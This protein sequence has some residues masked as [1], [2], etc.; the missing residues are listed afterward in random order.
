MPCLNIQDSLFG[1]RIL[2]LVYT[3]V[4]RLN[5][6][7]EVQRAPVSVITLR[8]TLHTNFIQSNILS[9]RH[10]S[11]KAVQKDVP[12]CRLRRDIQSN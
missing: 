10:G 11:T 2:K 6:A 3:L 4:P 5:D 9:F 7:K 8:E 1:R 12:C